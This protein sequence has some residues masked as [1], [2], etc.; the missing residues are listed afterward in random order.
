MAMVNPDDFSAM[1]VE[2]QREADRWVSRVEPA[3]GR[4]VGEGLEGR[5]RACLLLDAA[6]DSPNG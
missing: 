2:T 1:L 4:D 3:R 6:I 5:S